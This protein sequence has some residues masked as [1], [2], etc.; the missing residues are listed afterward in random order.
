[1]KKTKAKKSCASVPLKE[2][3]A[4]QKKM[5]QLIRRGELTLPSSKEFYKFKGF[6][7]EVAKNLL[8]KYKNSGRVKKN[9]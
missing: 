1:M 7:C 3:S 8:I 4:N 2:L 5:C 9:N 6:W